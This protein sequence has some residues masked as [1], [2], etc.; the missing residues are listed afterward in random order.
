MA[1]TRPHPSSSASVAPSSAEA[2]LDALDDGFCVVSP[3]WRILFVNAA[4]T[5][6]LGGRAD[7]YVGRALW[8][9]VPS[10]TGAR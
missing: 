8:E 2:A 10:L 9:A 6:L 3:E 4:F 7:E 5:R 1:G